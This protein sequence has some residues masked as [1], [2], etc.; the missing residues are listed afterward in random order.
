MVSVCFEI[1]EIST[2]RSKSQKKIT[3]LSRKASAIYCAPLSPIPFDRISSRVSV[4]MRR[5]SILIIEKKR[6]NAY[7][8]TSKCISQMSHPLCTDFVPSK[9][10]CGECL[11]EKN[12]DSDDRKKRKRCSPYS[13]GKHW[14]KNLLHRHQFHSFQDGVW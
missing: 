8:I 14:L 3:V 4:Y 13:F 11:C 1:V 2:T 12:K 5:I 9:I 7:F 6:K 10:E